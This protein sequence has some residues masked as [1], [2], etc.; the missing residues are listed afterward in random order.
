M[1]FNFPLIL[2]SVGCMAINEITNDEEC[3]LNTC[4]QFERKSISRVRSNRDGRELEDEL[5]GNEF[6]ENFLF[7]VANAAYQVEGAWNEDG[8]K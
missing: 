4:C 5:S 7:G 2:L 8:E 3:L 1:I 6:P